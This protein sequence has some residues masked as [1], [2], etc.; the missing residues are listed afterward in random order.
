MQPTLDSL[1]IRQVARL[2]LSY[3]DDLLESRLQVP[4]AETSFMSFVCAVMYARDHP[5]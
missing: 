5:V 4:E 1:G 3:I 2:F